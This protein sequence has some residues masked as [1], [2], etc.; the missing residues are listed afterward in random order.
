VLVRHPPVLDRKTCLLNGGDVGAANALAAALEARVVEHESP[1]P[2]LLAVVGRERFH[3]LRR[4]LGTSPVDDLIETV[5][6]PV[7]VAS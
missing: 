5:D 4:R 1:D 2:P 7:A 3:G 6:C